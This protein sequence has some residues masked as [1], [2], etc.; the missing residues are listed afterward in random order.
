MTPRQ[1]P[2]R[3]AYLGSDANIILKLILKKHGLSLWTALI[4]LR[5]ET[6]GGLLCTL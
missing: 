6:S 3:C 4:W 5:I 1:S 2:V